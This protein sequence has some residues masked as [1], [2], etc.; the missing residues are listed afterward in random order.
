M[1]SVQVKCEN[2]GV[3]FQMNLEVNS[4]FIVKGCWVPSAPLEISVQAKEVERVNLGEDKNY[5]KGSLG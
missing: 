4:K 2:Q 3:D 5:R 1:I